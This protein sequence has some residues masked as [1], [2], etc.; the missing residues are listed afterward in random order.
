MVNHWQIESGLGKIF[1][2][3]LFCH[4]KVKNGLGNFKA[5]S[6]TAYSRLGVMDDYSAQLSA[7]LDFEPL[8]AV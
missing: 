3:A 8:G 7:I 4:T 2:F 6:R 5:L 1:N